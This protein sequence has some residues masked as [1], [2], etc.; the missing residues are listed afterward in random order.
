MRHE[1]ELLLAE[2]ESARFAFIQARMARDTAARYL[3][4][5]LDDHAAMCTAWDTLA[6]KREEMDRA[7]DHL[8]TASSAV[9]AFL[10]GHWKRGGDGQ[11]APT[12]SSE[13]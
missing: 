6:M 10:M 11:G 9:I 1:L 4:A 5:V 8:A 13:N 2:R 12:T 7:C 3:D